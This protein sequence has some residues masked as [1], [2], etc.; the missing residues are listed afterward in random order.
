MAKPKEEAEKPDKLH[1]DV[2]SGLKRVLGRELITND[3]VAI[4]ELVKNSFDAAATKVFL[5]FDKS[6]IVVAD[7]GDGMSYADITGKWLSVAYS[8]KKRS[9][10]DDY[11]D[12]AAG[13]GH[14]A[15]SKGIGRFSSDRL[16]S[17]VVLQTRPR[18]PRAAP[19]E[20]LT[21][22]WQRFDRND[23]DRFE[24]IPVTYR[25]ARK[26][27]LP[28]KLKSSGA[29]INH[30]T[31]I[32]ITRLRQ[33]WDRE[34][35]QRLKAALAKLINPFGA[36]TDNF[37][38]TIVAPDQEEEDRIAR[39]RARRH[40]NELTPRDI[41]NGRVGNFI[42]DALRAKTTFISVRIQSGYIWTTLTDRGEAI[43]KIRE[44][45]TYKRLSNASVRCD[46][47]YLNQSAKQTFARRMGVP[48]IR[49]GSVFL[50]RNGFRVYPIGEEA[51]DWFGYNRRKQQGYSRFL[52]SRE[53]IGRLDVSGE[54]RDFQEASSRNQALIETPAVRELQEF[55]MEYCLKRLER[56]VVPVSWVD[57]GEKDADD[58]SRLLTDPG[59]AR[60]TAAVASL[61][62]NDQVELLNYSTRL[63]DIL[64]ER[65]A[66]FETSI[67]GL[68]AIAEK[69]GDARL[70]KKIAV[71]E[72]RYEELKTS[73]AEARRIADEER[74]RA[75]AAEAEAE[76]A[77]E[78]SETEKRR[79]HF[80]ETA[81]NVDAATI[82]NLHH[83]VTIY[84]G[85]MA[86]QIE[87]FLNATAGQRAVPRD[88]VLKTVEQIAY[89]NA[90]IH[91]IARFAARATFKLKSELITTDLAEFITDFIDG[92]ARHFSSSRMRIQV[93]N[94]HSLAATFNP[95]DV[96]IVVDNLMS[97]ASKA[98]ASRLSFK[99]D[100]LGKSGLQILVEDNGRGIPPSVDRARIFEMGFT[101]T[102]GAGLGLYHV[103]QVLG[104][105]GGT[106]ELVKSDSKGTSFL[107]KILPSKRAS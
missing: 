41:I 70:L 65:S 34:T 85:S 73:E 6:R 97:N 57:R 7:N 3:E 79:S 36:D 42:F 19:V 43:Y 33:E 89:L 84:S 77:K 28:E 12:V 60:V 30:G 31:V 54:D 103:R 32:E 95:I 64:N 81:I 87:N 1:F 13:R 92:I 93:E 24:A 29:A 59:R 100:S 83:Q 78:E 44:K 69:S 53:I 5:Y 49:F 40:E 35:L 23:L 74:A 91:S 101:T 46:V 76:T 15:G 2:K 55:F 71:A 105:M 51:D 102:H 107:I 63:V 10:S 11:R 20:H 22:N 82:L 98:R 48:S 104:E 37:S 88:V 14:F 61:V 8:A 66:E 80:L 21:I 18:K 9:Q 26:F 16:G 90:K 39:T 86:Q 38:I 27:E 99:I 47:Y 75:D 56:Y 72:R 94:A 68:R 96:S 106:I 62:D 25:E 58:L 4:F 50:F 52:G 45:N 67:V 17:L